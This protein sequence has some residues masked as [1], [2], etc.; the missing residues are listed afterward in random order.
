MVSVL[1]WRRVRLFLQEPDQVFPL[2]HPCLLRSSCW[3]R[4]MPSCCRKKFASIG[5]HL[6]P[7][8]SMYFTIGDLEI[9]EHL[10]KMASDFLKC[11]FS[12]WLVIWSLK[13]EGLYT[14]C[15]YSKD[16]QHSSYLGISH[17]L[18]NWQLWFQSVFCS[19]VRRERNCWHIECQSSWSK[20]IS[21]L[22][23]TAEEIA[24][25]MHY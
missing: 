25:L 21:S 4:D 19:S 2:S 13:K 17:P 1:S 3:V 6:V 16:M 22:N 11:F 5:S 10:S 24:R 18:G 8:T 12:V 14:L 20:P 15:N 7:C 23:F 9:L